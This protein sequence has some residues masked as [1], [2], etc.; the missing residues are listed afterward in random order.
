MPHVCSLPRRPSQTNSLSDPCRSQLTK[1]G[2]GPA[3]CRRP[4][5]STDRG[6]DGR[7][8]PW[9][10]SR[11]PRGPSSPL[12]PLCRLSLACFSSLVASQE[13]REEEF[14]FVGPLSLPR[15]ARC[16]GMSRSHEGATALSRFRRLLQGGRGLCPPGT[17]GCCIR[18]A[19]RERR[20]G[21]EGIL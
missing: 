11:S 10:P 12:H 16:A 9:T 15:V 7:T 17:R 2:P 18:A 19:A 14:F 3:A 5:A 6:G 13:R 20:S 21:G 1:A 8:P 4:S